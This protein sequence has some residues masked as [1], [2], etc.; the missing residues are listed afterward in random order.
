MIIYLV[1]ALLILGGI[2]ALAGI[3]KQSIQY[4]AV[5]LLVTVLAVFIFVASGGKL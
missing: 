2:G 3:V 4:T 1:L 5:G